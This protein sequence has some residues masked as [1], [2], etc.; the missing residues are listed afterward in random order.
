MRDFPFNPV[1]MTYKVSHIK[2]RIWRIDIDNIGYI[3]TFADFLE[4]ADAS[5]Q[6]YFTATLREEGQSY[7]LLKFQNNVG[8]SGLMVKRGDKT[9]LNYNGKSTNLL[10]RK[11]FNL[12]YILE[13]YQSKYVNP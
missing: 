4:E 5:I 7:L 13:I 6:F 1:T 2:D 12:L 3:H 9:T 10:F 8:L 11:R